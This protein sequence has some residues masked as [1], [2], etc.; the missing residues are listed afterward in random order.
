MAPET[1]WLVCR[2]FRCFLLGLFASFPTLGQYFTF[3][4]SCCSCSQSTLNTVTH[5]W[6]C[7]KDFC[8]VMISACWAGCVCVFECC[9]KGCVCIYVFVC[10]C[11]TMG[12]CVSVSVC[13]HA[14]GALCVCV[15][16]FMCV[17]VYLCYFFFS[18]SESSRL[19]AVL[20]TKGQL[21]CTV[22]DS[23]FH[24]HKS[25]LTLNR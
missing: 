9:M 22:L 25:H 6:H 17:C 18:T 16:M 5:L 24:K 1:L 21:C 2:R 4:T 15:S 19:K 14:C 20:N 12:A 23:A 7:L 11:V 8:Y 3:S 10:V 13:V